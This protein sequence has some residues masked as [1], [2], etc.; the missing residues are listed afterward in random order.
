VNSCSGLSGRGH[1]G[2]EGHEAVLARLRAQEKFCEELGAA[3][4]SEGG[5]GGGVARG[6]NLASFVANQCP[7]RRIQTHDPKLVCGR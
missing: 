2:E 5:G 4:V 6:C 3:E 1:G 7:V